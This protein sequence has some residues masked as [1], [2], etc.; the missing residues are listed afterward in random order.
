MRTR[1]TLITIVLLA[2]A[3]LLGGMRTMALSNPL[4]MVRAVPDAVH[5]SQTTVYLYPVA[6]AYVSQGGPTTNFGSATKLDVQNLDAE[7]PDD[8]R[9]YVGFDLSSIPS[10]AII[11]SAAFKAYL[12]EA[13]GL[14]NVYIQLRRV[15]SSWAYNTVTWNNKPSSKPFTG[16]YVNKTAGMKGWD[17]TSLVQNYWINRN[18]G[19]SPNFGLELRGPESGD[20]YLRRFY[21][22]DA[23]SNKPYLARQC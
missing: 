3:V 12:Y 6:D 1:M 5:L 15:I 20:Y 14:S 18:F 21:S 4:P 7:I 17:V 13:W 10:N 16:M 23:K 19:A 8:R 11:S 9:S 2:V 22:G